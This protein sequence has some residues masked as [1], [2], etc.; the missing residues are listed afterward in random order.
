MVFGLFKITYPWF[1]FVRK[2]VDTNIDHDE[3]IISFDFV[4]LLTAIVV[5]KT[6]KHIRNKRFEDETLIETSQIVYWRYYYSLMF[7]SL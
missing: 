2:I 7:Y 4:S 1:Y 3:I 5:D 6:C